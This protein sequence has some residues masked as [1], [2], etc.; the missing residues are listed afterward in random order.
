MELKELNLSIACYVEEAKRTGGRRARRRALGAA[1]K[2]LNIS[3]SQ[4]ET[5]VD[6]LDDQ[7]EAWIVCLEDGE[8]TDVCE[9]Y[10]IEAV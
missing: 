9:S 5:F 8:I 3:D 6:F 1:V 7:G 2:I 4:G 10:V